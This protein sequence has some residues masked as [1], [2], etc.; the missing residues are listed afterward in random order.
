MQLF[1]VVPLNSLDCYPMGGYRTGPFAAP[2]LETGWG[3]FDG[4]SCHTIPAASCLPRHGF[5][6]IHKLFTHMHIHTH[7]HTC[8]H[9]PTDTHTHTHTH[10]YTCPKIQTRTRIHTRSYTQ[11]EFHT[12]TPA[13]TCAGCTMVDSSDPEAPGREGVSNFKNFGATAAAEKS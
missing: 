6:H 4:A 2:P 11:N 10:T 12:R 5:A 1:A 8:T 9:A 3:I 13:C 7:I